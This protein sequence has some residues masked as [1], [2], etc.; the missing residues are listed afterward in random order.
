[1]LLR[2]FAEHRFGSFYFFIFRPFGSTAQASTDFLITAT[3]DTIS[4]PFVRIFEDR[5]NIRRISGWCCLISHEK[6]QEALHFFL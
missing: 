1:M 5:R 2:F 6:R 3:T 4:G